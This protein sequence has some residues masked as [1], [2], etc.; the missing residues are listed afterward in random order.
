[1][2]SKTEK[3]ERKLE[4]YNSWNRNLSVK[5]QNIF[6]VFLFFILSI[7]EECI[8]RNKSFYKTREI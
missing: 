8:L 3:T 2:H 6:L 5:T 4:L 1:M 7:T